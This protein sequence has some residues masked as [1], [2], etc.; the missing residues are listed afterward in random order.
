MGEIWRNNRISFYKKVYNKS[1][2]HFPSAKKQD[3]EQ[4]SEIVCDLRI[5][6]Q[7]GLGG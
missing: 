1:I 4:S 6:K 7:N 2:P 5:L 3:S